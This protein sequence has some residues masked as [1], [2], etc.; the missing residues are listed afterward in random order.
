MARYPMDP[1]QQIINC[2]QEGSVMQLASVSGE[3]QPWVCTV[4]FVP[5]EECRLYWLSLP[6]ERHSQELEAHSR[7]AV[8]VAYKTDQPVIGV[9]GEGTV[10]KVEDPEIVKQ[11][12]GPYIE[13]YGSGE[14]FYENFVRQTNK[15]HMYVFTPERFQLFDEVN[16]PEG[17]KRV[18]TP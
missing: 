17:S 3:N 4:Y 10:S 16:F 1:K 18:W 7:A 11:I 8:A 15:H 13:K 12:M 9:Q 14:Q 2:L 6:T 5:D